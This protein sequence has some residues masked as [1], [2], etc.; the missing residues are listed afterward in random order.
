MTR[1]LAAARAVKEAGTKLTEPPKPLRGEVSSVLSVLSEGEMPKATPP[2]R[3]PEQLSRDLYEERAA[4]REYDGA[5]DRAEAEAAAWKE[6]VRAPG[7]TAL[8]EW[9]QGSTKNPNRQR[10]RELEAGNR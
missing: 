5:Q 7:I 9:R 3:P 6:A 1:W 10:A 2:M 4:I 8:D